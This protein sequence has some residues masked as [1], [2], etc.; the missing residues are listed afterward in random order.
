MPKYDKKNK[1][2]RNGECKSYNRILI[3]A[4]KEMGKGGEEMESFDEHSEKGQEIANFMEMFLIGLT[5]NYEVTLKEPA[6]DIARR[7]LNNIMEF[8]PLKGE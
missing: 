6:D 3:N 2:Y 5:Q 1:G 8:K 4:L 7:F